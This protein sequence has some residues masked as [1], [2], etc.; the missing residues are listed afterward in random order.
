MRAVL[1][2]EFGPP[3]SLVIEEVPDPVPGPDEVVVDVAAA[4][5][6][7]PD[8]LT[9]RDMYQFK[10]PMPFSPGGEFA[11]TV[12]AVGT[13][14]DNVAVGDRVIA[15]QVAGGFAEKALVSQ[16]KALLPIPPGME[17]VAAASW[18]L[19]YGTSY[20]ALKD[21]AE[22]KEGETILVLGA[23]GGVGLAA[24]DLGRGLGLRV[25]AAASTEEKLVVCRQYGAAATINY[26]T[27]DLKERV[28]EL[29]RG[30]GA[31]I[32]V[33]PVGG[34]YTEAALRATAWKGR[35]LVVG[36]TAGD[37]PRIPLN[38]TLLK[39]CDIRGVFWGSFTQ[40]NPELSSRNLVDLVAMQQDGRIRP[41]ISARYPLE[42]APQAIADLL[43][44]RATGKV[45]VEVASPGGE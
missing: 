6:N 32:V 19:A 11:G 13:G 44:R 43:E 27:E 16:P 41:Y 36:F 8:T 5:V 45:I 22:A 21:R 15:V 28:K 31:D 25:I 35:L 34:D 18:V 3:S 12:S 26:T 1:C 20:Y 7:Y 9:I 17:F 4:S 23:A 38:L 37:I 2:K 39:G 33:D 14:V 10:P 40:R 42:Q 24:V 30:A 29:T